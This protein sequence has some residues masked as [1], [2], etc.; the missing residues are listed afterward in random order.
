[1]PAFGWRA[2]EGA[3]G[4]KF[5]LSD[6]STFATTIMDET[7]GK[8]T[9]I[10]SAETLEWDTIYFWRVKALR[11][12][13]ESDWTDAAFNTR[14]EVLEGPPPPEVTVQAPPMPDITVEAPPAPPA[15]IPMWALLLVIILGVILVI[16][17]I[18]LV[19][20]TTRI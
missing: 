5:Q 19:M 10:K 20:R 4:Y 1:M 6:D 17:I 16:A 8:A 13:V 12:V 3:T 11:D 14:P 2:V 15:P 7:L 18:I 9:S